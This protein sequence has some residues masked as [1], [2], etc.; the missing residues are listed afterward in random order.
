[1]A[2]MTEPDWKDHPSNGKVFIGTGTIIREAV[3]IN[4]P[5]QTSTIIG[6]DCY[7]MNRCFIGHDSMI[8][9][10][11]TLSPGC[12]IAGFVKIGDYSCVGMNASVHQH[13]KLGNYCMVGANSFFKG[14]SPDGITWGGVPAKPIKVNE[15]GIN[16]SKLTDIEKLHVREDAEL[17]INFFQNPSNV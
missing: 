17:F 10:N 11:V 3:I 5:T 2:Q 1:M 9:N 15:V 16:R 8:G 13:S 14:I 7:L 6:C 12:S 4:K